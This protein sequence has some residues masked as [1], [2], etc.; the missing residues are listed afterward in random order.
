MRGLNDR[1][2][3]TTATRLGP[4]DRVFSLQRTPAPSADSRVVHLQ[5]DL[6]EIDAHAAALRDYV[7]A[8]WRH[9]ASK[10]IVNAFDQPEAVSRKKRNRR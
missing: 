1:P 8:A 3:L 4:D 10:K 2:V 7:T 9:T 5:G 6:R